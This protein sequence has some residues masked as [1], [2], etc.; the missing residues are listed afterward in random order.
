ML[1]TLTSSIWDSSDPWTLSK[2]LPTN[3]VFF[4]GDAWANP[5]LH[6][7]LLNLQFSAR[8]APEHSSN[9]YTNHTFWSW[10]RQNSCSK[11]LPNLW[12][13]FNV[14]KRS[15]HKNRCAICAI[16]A[17]ATRTWKMMKMTLCCEKLQTWPHCSS[18]FSWASRPSGKQT[19]V[20]RFRSWT[21]VEIQ[22]AKCHRASKWKQPDNEPYWVSLFPQIHVPGNRSCNSCKF[23]KEK[24][25]QAKHEQSLFWKSW[26]VWIFWILSIIW[27]CPQNRVSRLWKFVSNP[28]LVVARWLIATFSGSFSQSCPPT[29]NFGFLLLGHLPL[30]PCGK[31]FTIFT[32]LTS[33][34]VRATHPKQIPKCKHEPM[35]CW[36]TPRTHQYYKVI[37]CLFGAHVRSIPTMLSPGSVS[38]RPTR[39]ETLG[40][41]TFCC[42]SV[43][44]W[45][46]KEIAE[47]YAKPP[48]DRPQ[49][50]SDCSGCKLKKSKTK[51]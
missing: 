36:G 24:N 5:M 4:P 35:K 14:W 12:V 30:Q 38:T 6:H 22:S 7:G 18:R 16:L 15:T 37:W 9:I 26:F 31:R 1:G 19:I 42:W 41:Q 46:K 23:L 20:R 50:I 11:W 2:P 25:N 49:Y 44:Q 43:V 13:Q 3:Y 10:N 28:C 21:S 51:N 33:F 48:Q 27:T 45:S 8:V 39:V 32:M 40:G 17:T 47:H 29:R 34:T